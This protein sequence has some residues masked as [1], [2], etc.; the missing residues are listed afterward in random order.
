MRDR[1]DMSGLIR[2]T[3]GNCAQAGITGIM[4]LEAA[5]GYWGMSSYDYRAH[6]IFLY[7]TSRD[8]VIDLTADVSFVGVP[9]ELTYDNTM[10]LG[11][12]IYVTD[13]ERTICD[14]IACDCDLFHLIETVDDYYN[15]NTDTE[16]LESMAKKRGVYDKLLEIKAIAE[17]EYD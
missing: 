4:G 17:E 13:K 10:G 9:W 12:G 14:M 8:R 2:I 5:S 11:D 15:N 3:F 16:K 1:T 7:K 6:P